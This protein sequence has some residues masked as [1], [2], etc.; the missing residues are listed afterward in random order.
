MDILGHEA[1]A[2][3]EKTWFFFNS[4]IAR[5]CHEFKPRIVGSVWVSSGLSFKRIEIRPNRVLGGGEICSSC[6]LVVSRQGCSLRRQ[7]RLD[8]LGGNYGNEE[9]VLVGVAIL[10]VLS[11]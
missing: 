7:M 2:V 3:D 6:E 8:I 1:Y 11:Q 5:H 4:D 10:G 9:V